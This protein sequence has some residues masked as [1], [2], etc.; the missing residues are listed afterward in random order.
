MK[1]A[2]PGEPKRS[3]ERRGSGEAR[4]GV[5]SQPTEA[6]I[7][8]A[9][10][11]PEEAPALLGRDPRGLLQLRQHLVLELAADRRQPARHRPLVDPVH[12]PD[13]VEGEAVDV[14]QP[15]QRSIA[16]RERPQ[17]L[18]KR[19]SKER[20]EPLVI[21]RKLGGKQGCCGG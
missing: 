4:G 1:T 16:G 20:K 12:D 17:G 13:R 5:L 7:N 14:V 21:R 2:R 6:Q 9:L 11:H 19:L 18:V 8:A 3:A 15:Q 10:Q